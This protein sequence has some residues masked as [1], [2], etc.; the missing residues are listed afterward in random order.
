MNSIELI[1]ILGEMRFRFY[2]DQIEDI[3]EYLDKMISD[4]RVIM[5]DNEHG[6][7]VVVT[8]S[9]TN[10]PDEFLKKDTWEYKPHD[11]RGEIVYVEKL[12]STGWNRDLREILER[13]ITE[14]YPNI[15]FAVWHKYARWG[16]RMV[17]SKR[18]L[19]NV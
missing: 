14:L 9:V 13:K 19:Q 3:I 1:N 10:S 17:I 7:C 15:K 5:I 8:F 6:P 16:D 4:K 2:D 11:K 12:M 18:R